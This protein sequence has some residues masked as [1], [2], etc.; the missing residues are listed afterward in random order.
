MKTSRR[1][2][3]IELLVVIAIIAILASVLLPALS[4]SKAKAKAILCSSNLKQV[5]TSILFYAEDHMGYAPTPLEPI[6]YVPCYNWA[7]RLK[8]S[9]YLDYARSGSVFLCPSWYPFIFSE[10]TGVGGWYYVYGMRAELAGSYRGICYNIY[11]TEKEA[12]NF[13]PSNFLLF[14]DSTRTDDQNLTQAGAIFVQSVH[15]YKVH[16]RHSRKANTWFADGS[17]RPCGRGELVNYGVL[18]D[19][20]VDYY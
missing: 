17:V 12:G 1:F 3:L 13:G 18:A 19:Q 2:T 14:S 11:R 4:M 9:G 6:P 15:T 16:A 20:T 7:Q 5:G 10:A 8:F